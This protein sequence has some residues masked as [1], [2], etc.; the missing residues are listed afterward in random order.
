MSSWRRRPIP[1][2]IPTAAPGTWRRRPSVPTRRSRPNSSDRPPAPRGEAGSPPRR[3][4]WTARPSSAWTPPP[5]LA[6]PG[7]GP[8][9]VPRGC[10]R[11]RREAAAD[12]R[13][14]AAGR[15]RALPGGHDPGPDRLL[16]EPR[17]RRAALLLRAAR[18]LE[19]LDLRMAR[20]TYLDAVLARHFA[21]RLAPGSLREA[22]EA[23][24]R[25][26]PAQPDPPWPEP[27]PPR[28]PISCSTAWRRR[29][30]A[31]TPPACQCS[32]LL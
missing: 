13:G 32:A 3:R 10:S 6:A 9:Q 26:P 30:P 11:S 7:R 20:Q 29:S 4:S 18:R 14:R 17:P 21:G 2:S 28:P 23:A 25:V 15:T 22:A 16:A 12:R 8:G 1:I 31:D 27:L 5:R 19:P 24:R